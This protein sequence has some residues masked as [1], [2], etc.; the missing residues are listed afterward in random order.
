MG[1]HKSVEGNA[2]K[3]Q[4]I[5]FSDIIPPTDAVRT[6]MDPVKMDELIQSIRNIGLIN[7]ISVK[8]NGEKWEIVAGHRRY[9]AL[10]RIGWFYIPCKIIGQTTQSESINL[11]ENA[12]R[13]DINPLDEAIHLEK[14]LKENPDYT[15][16]ELANIAGRSEAYISQ[17]LSILKM[18]DCLKNALKE[19]QINF[20]VARELMRIKDPDKLEYFS[21]IA[22]SNGASPATARSWASSIEA[23]E[24][25]P[26]IE[27]QEPNISSPIPPAIIQQFTCHACHEAIADP[28]MLTTLVVCRSCKVEIINFIN[29]C[30]ADHTLDET[31]EKYNAQHLAEASQK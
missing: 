15:H 12:M 26:D 22:I 16:K 10:E 20:S 6:S 13:E 5:P 30:K 14:V 2:Y 25:A 1:R 31:A 23:E 27:R 4:S 21:N 9:I 28:N 11:Q 17:R 29:A 18:P 3:V 8:L 24:K 7:P 19:E